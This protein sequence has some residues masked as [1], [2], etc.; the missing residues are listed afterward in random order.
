MTGPQDS[1]NGWER[2]RGAVDQKL[3]NHGQALTR[4][5]KHLE[6]LANN[7]VNNRIKLAVTGVLAGCGG[8]GIGAVII[9]YLGG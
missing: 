9:K 7:V 3:D 5:E 4:I 1:P 2:W 8:T 6:K